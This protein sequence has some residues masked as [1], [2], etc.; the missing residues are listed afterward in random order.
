VEVGYLVALPVSKARH[1]AR[2]WGA[3]TQSGS[4]GIVLY[5][6]VEMWWF[7]KTPLVG[8]VAVS[9]TANQYYVFRPWQATAW[10]TSEVLAR[11]SCHQCPGRALQLVQTVFVVAAALCRPSSAA[12]NSLQVFH[13][14][15]RTLSISPLARG[16]IPGHELGP[17]IEVFSS[18]SQKPQRR[19]AET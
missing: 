13:Q 18:P 11:R 7:R 9:R 12:R 14:R 2:I 6:S 17:A 8:D 3:P 16:P 1:P 5:S 19:S 15:L 10:R 4:L